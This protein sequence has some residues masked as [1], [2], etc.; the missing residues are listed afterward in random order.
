MIQD[1][2]NRIDQGVGVRENG[3][4]STTPTSRSVE[5]DPIVP[6]CLSET[7]EHSSSRTDLPSSKPVDRALVDWVKNEGFDTSVIEKV[8]IYILRY[9]FFTNCFFLFY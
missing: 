2:S 4:N 7:L 6:I 5:R 8:N 3:S 9:I 1:I